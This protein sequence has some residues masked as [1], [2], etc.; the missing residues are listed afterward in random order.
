MLPPY[1]NHTERAITVSGS[2]NLNRLKLGKTSYWNSVFTLSSRDLTN[3]RWIAS[4]LL[5][6]WR[7]LGSRSEIR[8]RRCSRGLSC[9]P[10][11][12][13]PRQFNTAR[14]RDARRADQETYSYTEMDELSLRRFPTRT[15]GV[16]QASPSIH[17]MFGI[18]TPLKGE[19]NVKERPDKQKRPVQVLHAKMS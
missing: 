10:S 14:Q 5:P 16:S 18:N 6:L 17:F 15:T 11:L 13:K 2:C 19:E 4:F 12:Q 8:W 3:F 1:V 7:W 9:R